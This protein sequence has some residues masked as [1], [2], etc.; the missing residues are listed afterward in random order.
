MDLTCLCMTHGRTF[1]LE[2]SLESYLR[3]DRTGLLCEFLIFNDCPEQELLCDH[4]EVRIINSSAPIEDLS[5]KQ[6]LGVELSI[7]QWTMLWDDDDIWLSFR[8]RN[9]FESIENLKCRA[10]APHATWFWDNGEITGRGRRPHY[11]SAC[12]ETDFY[13]SS[14]GAIR[15]APP[16]KSAWRNMLA[17]GKCVS[18]YRTA[19]KTDMIYRWQGTGGCHDSDSSLQVS[20]N[21]E[22]HR[23][24]RARTLASS[25]FHSGR[26]ELKPHWKQDYEQLVADAIIAGK[27]G[28]TL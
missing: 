13:K 28:V 16:D 25:L 9:A 4:P 20:G 12:F 19:E 10:V 21:V 2:E 23:I 26:I 27:G 1:L 5:L 7:G 11:G 17:R 15:N 6:N 18:V 22:R 14:G 24:F 8:I 3:Q